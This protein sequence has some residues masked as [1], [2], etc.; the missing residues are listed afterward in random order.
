MFW[1]FQK[2]SVIVKHN[3]SVSEDWALAG[4]VT[5]HAMNRHVSARF[6]RRRAGNENQFIWEIIW[7]NWKFETETKI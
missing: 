1:T 6:S 7:E 3:V 5:S 4:E 2:K